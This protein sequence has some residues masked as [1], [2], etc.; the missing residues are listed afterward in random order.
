MLSRKKARCYVPEGKQGGHSSLTEVTG[1]LISE[2]RGEVSQVK[3]GR[4]A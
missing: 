3:G 2:M 1:E 4:G